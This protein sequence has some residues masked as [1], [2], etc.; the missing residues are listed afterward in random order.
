MPEP[1]PEDA[2]RWVGERLDIEAE[3]PPPLRALDS[4]CHNEVM[5]AMGYPPDQLLRIGRLQRLF[6]QF[7]DFREHTIHSP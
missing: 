4:I 2:S 1:T 3:E 6:S 7:F 5:R